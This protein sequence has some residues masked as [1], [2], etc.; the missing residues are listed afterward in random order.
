MNRAVGLR[1]VRAVAATTVVLCV[2]ACAG[3]DRVRVQLQAHDPPDR[4]PRALELRAQVTGSQAGLRYQ[5]F[6]VAG[7]AEPQVSA[8]PATTFRF[9][10]GSTRDR[11]TL[12][13]WRGQRRVGR[14]EIDVQLDEMKVRQAAAQPP[15][16]TVEITKV[17]PYEPAGGDA[18][19]AD[20]A[21][22]VT[23]VTSPAYQV[24]IYARADAWYIQP[25]SHTV[26]PIAS[27]GTWASWTHTGSSYAALVVRPGFGALTRY[28][29]LPQVGGH[30][31]ARTIVEGRRP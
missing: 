16:V 8:S 11:V 1:P 23:G 13:V 3:E 20:I 22:R 31:V 25:H 5:W 17:P 4:D 7:Q 2:A 12:E 26:H 19:R 15:N 9:A 10:D 24:V 6:S 21:G 29:V 30:V 28:D 27:D 18:T 14:G